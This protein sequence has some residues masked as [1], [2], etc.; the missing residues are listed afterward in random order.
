MVS[1]SRSSFPAPR[2]LSLAGLRVV[3][4][5]EPVSAPFA[6]KLLADLGA[7]VIL[8]EPPEGARARAMGPFPGDAPHA[9]R[10][11]E[12]LYLNANKLGVTLDLDSPTGRRILLDLLRDADVF[13]EQA[14]PGVMERRDL[15]HGVLARVNPRLIVTSIRPFGLRGPYRDYLGGDLIVW[16]GSALGHRYLGEPDREPLRGSGQYASF[17]AGVNAAAATMLAYHAREAP[18]RRGVSGCEGQQVDI[19]QMDALC[20]STLGYGLVALFY[21]RGIHNRRTGS[22]QRLG[23]PAALMQC[24]DGWV[25]IFASE[26]HM[27]EGLVKAMGEPEWAKAEIFKGRYRERARYAPEIYT[28]IQLWLDG[29]TKEEVFQRCQENRVPSTAVYN[30]AEV[31]HQRHLRERGFYVQMS[32]P[33]AGEYEAPGPPYRLSATP[34]SLRRP[35]PRLG[36]HNE[37]VLCGRL[38]LAKRELARLRQAGVV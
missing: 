15:T 25:F 29:L 30:V 20:V 31:F 9:E 1:S 7:E 32:H 13:I 19:S 34:W 10:S 21:E 17:Y 14:P 5:G 11:A 26:A 24:K 8:V 3:E 23:V 35:A 33:D 18:T 22:S 12:H 6:G 28:M 38:G 4:H 2:P 27:W 16:H 37:E 36:E